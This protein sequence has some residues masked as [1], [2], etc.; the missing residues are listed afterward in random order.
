M[1]ARKWTPNVFDT[2]HSALTHTHTRGR[3]YSHYGAAV[4][5]ATRVCSRSDNAIKID[6]AS[7][8][9][10]VL[11]TWFDLKHEIYAKAFPFSSFFICVCVGLFVNRTRD[12]LNTAPVRATQYT[13]APFSW[14]R[15]FP[16]IQPKMTHSSSIEVEE[17]RRCRSGISLENLYSNVNKQTYRIFC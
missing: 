13:K 11:R 4:L 5:S 14:N 15:I 2:A 16:E 10:V 8:E 17:N 7:G 6:V 12:R 1:D 3:E 9:A